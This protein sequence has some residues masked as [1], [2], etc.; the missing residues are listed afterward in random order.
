MHLLSFSALSTPLLVP[1]LTPR[2]SLLGRSFLL[3]RITRVNSQSKTEHIRQHVQG[4]SDDGKG[5][6]GIAAEEFDAHEREAKAHANVEGPASRK[7]GEVKTER[8]ASEGNAK[9]ERV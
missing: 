2:L 1:V 7:K 3:R 6:P 4:I 5:V 8:E 9:R